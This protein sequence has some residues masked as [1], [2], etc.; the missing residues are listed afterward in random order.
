VVVK[1]L[2]KAVSDY[3][4]IKSFAGLCARVGRRDPKEEKIP[5][6]SIDEQHRQPAPP[7]TPPDY[8]STPS[9][10]GQKLRWCDRPQ[11]IFQIFS[12]KLPF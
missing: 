12:P 4:K 8:N 1:S 3:L 5:V 9:K 6:P 7:Q 10:S 11:K 2:R